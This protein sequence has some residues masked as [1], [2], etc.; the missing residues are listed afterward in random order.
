MKHSVKRVFSLA[1]ALLL[2]SCGVFALGADSAVTYTGNKGTFTFAPGSAQSPTDLFDAFKGVMPG[3][4]LTEQVT[5]R[6]NADKTVY[7]KIYMRARGAQPGSEDLL[8]QLTLTVDQVGKANRLFE[9]P[10]DQTAQLTDWVLLGT[11][12][13]GAAVTLGVTLNVPLQLGNEL[14]SAMGAL[15]WEFRADEFPVPVG[16]GTGDTA[17]L[18]LY[19]TGLGIS[20]LVLLGLLFLRRKRKNQ[21]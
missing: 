4:V 10:A 18:W 2:L 5:V 1:L 19:A 7:V 11:F 6:N 9:A 20:G 16:P 3:D 13:S 12:Q 8:K 15:E 21:E 14:Q 17:P